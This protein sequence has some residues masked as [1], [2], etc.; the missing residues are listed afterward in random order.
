VLG[1]LSKGWKALSILR[2]EIVQLIIPWGKASKAKAKEAK[3]RN[4]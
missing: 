3:A 1:W 2:T 4:Q